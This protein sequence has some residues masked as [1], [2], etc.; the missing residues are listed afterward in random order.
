[1]LEASL[2]TQV[3]SQAVLQPAE[4]GRPMRR[5]TI[6]PASP[7]LVRGLAGRDGFVPSRSSNSLRRAGHMHADF[8]RQLYG[9]SSDKMV[10]LASR[11]SEQCGLAGSCFGGRTAL[12]LCIS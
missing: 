11:L 10:R 9:V 2:Q 8:G 6:G 12:D 5:R 1:M 3:Q 4:T 7:G